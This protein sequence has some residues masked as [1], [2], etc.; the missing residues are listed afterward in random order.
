MLFFK[1]KEIINE[2]GFTIMEAMV[3]V[4][5][6]AI[7][8]AVYLTN[9]RPT[10]QKIILDQTASG[11]VADLRYAQNMAMSVKKFNDEIPQGGYGVKINN[12]SP[13][14][15]TIYADCN[16]NSHVYDGASIVCKDSAGNVTLAEKVNDRI[17]DSKIRITT[18]LDISFQPPNPVVWIDGSTGVASSIIT[19]EYGTTGVTK[20]ITINGYTGQIS[21]D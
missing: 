2:R 6:I 1:N 14:T 10:N 16:I 3:T 19:L 4:A 11:L 18:A 15:Y 12:T 5:I 9:Y 17:L 7:M 20:T 13:G 21:A 8:S